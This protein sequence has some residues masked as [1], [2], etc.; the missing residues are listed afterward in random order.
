[1]KKKNLIAKD[2]RSPKYRS[3]VIKP[4]KGNTNNTIIYVSVF[5]GFTLRTLWRVF[6]DFVL[7]TIAT[8]FRRNQIAELTRYWKNVGGAVSC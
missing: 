7:L 1:M 5:V 2:L 8:Y 4:K 3:R 6:Y